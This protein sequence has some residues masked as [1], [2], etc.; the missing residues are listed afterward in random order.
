MRSIASLIQNAYAVASGQWPV[1]GEDALGWLLQLVCRAHN[2]WVVQ[3]RRW[4]VFLGIP[5]GKAR[6][7]RRRLSVEV[8]MVSII[9]GLSLGGFVLALALGSA[10]CSQDTGQAPPKG[11]G[12][13]NMMQQKMKEMGEKHGGGKGAAQPEDKDQEKEKDK[14]KEKTKDKEK[15]KAKQ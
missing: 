5:L 9:R 14:D 11:G 3:I 15:D 1:A 6:R 12:G 13:G 10:G 2:A 8:A 4:S 7:C